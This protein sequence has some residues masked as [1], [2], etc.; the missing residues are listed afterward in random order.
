MVG[1]FWDGK[2]ENENFT[3]SG[4]D[5]LKIVAWMNKNWAMKFHLYFSLVLSVEKRRILLGCCTE[6]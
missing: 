2:M 1:K 5:T 6:G 3:Y 4:L